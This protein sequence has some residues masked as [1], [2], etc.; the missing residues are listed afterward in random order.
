MSIENRKNPL[1]EHTA[2]NLVLRFVRIFIGKGIDK[3]AK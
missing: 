1:N 3:D 2:Q